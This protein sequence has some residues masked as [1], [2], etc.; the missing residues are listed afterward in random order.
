MASPKAPWHKNHLSCSRIFMLTSNGIH[1]E[2]GFLPR[3][4]FGLLFRCVL[5]MS[6][7]CDGRSEQG[8]SVVN[9]GGSVGRPG[10][11]EDSALFVGPP[12]TSKEKTREKNTTKRTKGRKTT[13]LSPL[14]LVCTGSPTPPPPWP[15]PMPTRTSLPPPSCPP[16]LSPGLSKACHSVLGAFLCPALCVV[17]VEATSTQ[18]L[19]LEAYRCARPCGGGLRLVA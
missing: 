15:P 12:T 6:S 1:V 3:H 16:S 14:R 19:G 11:A 7:L 9:G 13:I 10:E 4:V 5:V 17:V 2:F 18:I 8:H